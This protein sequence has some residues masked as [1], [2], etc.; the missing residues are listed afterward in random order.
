[1]NATIYYCHNCLILS[2]IIPQRN[3]VKLVAEMVD[4][5]IKSAVICM[6]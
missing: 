5:K 2:E 3:I 6:M 4:R 1:M